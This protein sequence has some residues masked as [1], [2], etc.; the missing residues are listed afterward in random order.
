MPDKYWVD[1]QIEEGNLSRAR[2]IRQRAISAQSRMS[3]EM[4]ARANRLLT[5]NAGMS[6]DLLQQILGMDIPDGPALQEVIDADDGGESDGGLWDGFRNFVGDRISDVAGVADDALS[7]L[8]E[9]GIKP[10]VRGIST[11][12]EALSHELVQRPISALGGIPGVTPG[13]GRKGLGQIREDYNAYGDSA[14]T[15]IIQGQTDNEA[16][17]GVLGTGFFAGGR[18]QAQSEAERTMQIRGQRATVGRA[19]A[20]STVGEFVE[21]G[22]FVY[23]LTAG[24]SGFA[25]EVILDPLAPVGGSLAK[26]AKAA[27]TL[28][29]GVD[30]GRAA[31]REWGQFTEIV[32]GSRQVRGIERGP[33]FTFRDE[34]NALGRYLQGFDEGQSVD[35]MRGAFDEAA[36]L[37]DGD[38]EYGQRLGEWFRGKGYEPDDLVRVYRGNE[39]AAPGVHEFTNVTLDPRVASKYRGDGEVSSYVVR[40]GDVKGIL[41]NQESE[42]LVR[43]A[44]LLDDAPALVP[45]GGGN[46]SRLDELALRTGLVRGA[47][48]NTII[49]ERTRNF[50]ADEK[51]L[52]RIAE[53]DTYEIAQRWSKSPANRI[54]LAVIN[55]LGEA[56]T[57][58]EVADVLFGAIK[59]GQ[60]TERGFFSGPGHFVRKGLTE[61][62]YTKP[63]RFLTRE[64]KYSGLAPTGTISAED[65]DGMAGKVDSLLRQANVPR[66]ERAEMFAKIAGIEPGDH[67][68]TFDVMRSTIR[69]IEP[70]LRG[71]KGTKLVDDLVDHYQGQVEAFRAYAVDAIGDP[72]Q[73]PFT[74]SKI[75]QNFDGTATDVVVPSPQLLSELNTLAMTLPDAQDIRRAA[76]SNAAMRAIYTSKGWD[77][78]ARAANAATTKVFKPLALL[79]PAYVVRIGTEEQ[80]RLIASGHDSI[81]SHPARFIMANMVARDEMFDLAGN[82]LMKVSEMNGVVAH[83]SVGLLDDPMASRARAFDITTAPEVGQR[84]SND[85]IRGWQ[86]ELGQLSSD[87]IA[88]KLTELYGD[89]DALKDWARG[90]G[91]PWVRRYAKSQGKEGQALLRFDDVFDDWAAGIRTRIEAKTAG[92]DE[93]LV[94]AV[95][96][97]AVPFKAEGSKEVRQFRDFLRGKADATNRPAAV[98]VELLTEGRKK[99]LDT[100]V[101]GLFDIITAKPTSYLARYPAFRSNIAVRTTEALDLL[102]T[103]ELREEVVEAAMKGLRLTKPE[104]AALR[105]AADSA[106]GKVG[107]VDNLGDF[108]EAIVARAADD[109][110]DLLFDV[111]KRGAAQE[112]FNVAVP[113]LD[114]WKEVSLTWMRLLK[115]NPSFFIRAQAG[116]REAGD[117][118]IFYQNDYGEEVF[119]YPGSGM[120]ANLAGAA[121]PAGIGAAV[122]GPLGAFDQA[123]PDGSRT[124]LEGR[125]Q[126]LNLIAQGIG[127]GFGP[128]IQWPA[129]MLKDPK[130]EVLQDFMAPFGVEFGS[131]TELFSIGDMAESFMPAW[132]KKFSNALTGGEI[133]ARQWN[134]TVGEALEAYSV[135]GEYDL[136]DPEQVQAMV[137]A[138]ERYATFILLGRSFTQFAGP[139]GASAAVEIE[140]D[141]DS[142]HEDWDPEQ[143]PDG[144]W[145]R[146]NVLGQEFYRLSDQYGS[147][148]AAQ[149]FFEM[150]GK[151]PWYIAQGATSTLGKELPVT[152]EGGRW[153]DQNRDVFEDHPLVAG[154]FAPVEEGA[155]LDFS[156]YTGQINRGE[157]K[158]LTPEEQSRLAQQ[159]RARAIYGEA[160][161]QLELQGVPYSQKQSQLAM[162]AGRLEQVSPGWRSPILAMPR[163]DDKINQLYRAVNDDK[164]ANNPL[165][166][167]L[168]AY[169]EMRDAALREVRRETGRDNATLAGEAAAPYRAELAALGTRLMAGDP[170][171]T[172]VWTSLLKRELEDD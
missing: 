71:E 163:P 59:S 124:V 111:T 140:A 144:K 126:G 161:R 32:G 51:F 78:T 67:S 135:S 11:A 118:G 100:L 68:A 12:S 66:E 84:A 6:G 170:A 88:R 138:A 123:G 117:Q 83:R 149:K 119:R 9:Q 106:R 107:V 134:S 25:T 96:D 61:S 3:P 150:Y 151:E 132:F 116:Y 131:P 171:F 26:G 121:L 165:T 128:L 166:D 43:S 79:R 30:G 8:Y 47:R 48:R 72:I 133:D 39:A 98:K 23:D 105:K 122:A 19:L 45:A 145:F 172:G 74:K 34:N 22:D 112:A 57:T 1:H 129:G 40:V 20:S 136:N 91:L 120:L 113:F 143:D 63:L 157:R 53:A 162:V 85:Y 54:N 44:S 125:V 36:R 154:F 141:A 146:L 41:G 82:P 89:T 10:L 109:V 37:I 87:P 2:A 148:Q 46:V 28:D 92:W 115:E 15:N 169:L 153:I 5:Q 33:S 31:V 52:S 73:T 86:G 104:Q 38:T 14:V 70:R 168:R 156:V 94:R 147:D 42:L 114:A 60:I 7:G 130:Y 110:R 158:S 50:F 93:D 65:I 4:G 103:D 164:L 49:A 81:F 18:A 77:W 24:V 75:T 29:R 101:D 21:P 90:E 108:N 62:K 56:K 155:D 58:D 152:T 167:P 64:G 55:A 142:S 27:R 69:L 159:T 76:T 102:A 35:E 137:S 160:Q 17:G 99:G 139:T 95:A 127:P 97:D 13:L 80:A 16:E